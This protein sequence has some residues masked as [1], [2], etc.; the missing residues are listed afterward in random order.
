[1]HVCKKMAPGN[2]TDCCEGQSV[3]LMM[4]LPV[5]ACPVVVVVVVSLD[6]SSCTHF[7]LQLA[8]K[9]LMSSAIKRSE[10]SY[11]EQVSRK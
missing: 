9:N 3:S 10:E 5:I 6:C 11:I 1:M 7:Y 2:E 8:D 4:T